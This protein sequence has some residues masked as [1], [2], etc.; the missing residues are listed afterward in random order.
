V[1]AAGFAVLFAALGASLDERFHESALLRT[2][3]ARRAQLR[4]AH[5]AE[6]AVLGLLAGLL[7]AIGTEFIAYALYTRVFD[8]EYSF[9]WPVWIAAPFLGAVSI[10]LAGYFG[11][12]RVVRQSPLTF[13]REA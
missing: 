4:A 5:F 2:L 12:R 10:G 3:G 1:L 7:A 8:L 6:F 13:L 11:A 9:K